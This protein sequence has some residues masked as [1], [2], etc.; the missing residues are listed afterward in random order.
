M[1]IDGVRQPIG[2]YSINSGA[3]TITFGSTPSGT[4]LAVT[5]YNL[6]D[7]QYL[8][9]QTITGVTVSS[10]ININNTISPALATTGVTAVNSAT[11]YLT[12]SNTS[13]FLLNA[14]VQFY[15]NA[16]LGNVDA[17]TGTVYFIKSIDS[18]TTF[19]ISTSPGGSVFD[20]GT[21]IGSI[22]AVVGGQPAV[23]V[24]TSSANLLSTNDI[25][26][27]SGTSGSVQLNE[28]LFYVHV[29]SSTQFD[30]YQTTYNPGAFVSNLPV[31]SITA[32]SGGGYVWKD[33]IFII[34]SQT[35]TAT[36]VNNK[37]TVGS[38]S[39][40]VVGTPI[41]FN[42]IGCEL[43][44]V[45][46]SNI[47]IGTKYFIHSITSSTEFTISTSHDG[48]IFDLTTQTG[49]FYTV[50][51]WEQ[52]IVDRLWV[53]VNGYRVAS[54]SLRLYPNND[55]GILTPIS[56][57]DSIIITSMIPTA[58]PNQL[59]YIQNVNK[60]G[61]SVVYRANSNISTWLTKSLQYTDT[62]IHL[63][64]VSNITSSTVITVSTPSPS[65]GVYTIG[66]PVDKNA[67]SEVIIYN[68]DA[69]VTLPSSYYRITVVDTV[70]VVQ[71]YNGVTVGQILTITVVLGNVIYIA[72]EAI[73]FSSV[74]FTTNT[75]S[76]LQRG[77][78][79]TSTPALIPID[80]R[81]YGILSPNQLLDEYYDMTWNS[82]NYNPV[83]GDPLQ[84]STTAPA[85]F[86][87]TGTS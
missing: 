21:A 45:T 72:G 77:V 36:N 60:S 59:T 28:Q 74:N 25:V 7:T 87:N 37:I 1:E 84:I 86:L 55:L 80:T 82:Y 61:S 17:T 73:R 81:V 2:N 53:T 23:R 54:S 27:I 76:G 10:I 22:V 30:L 40:L 6:T 3:N 62:I 78:N 9:T 14:T 44:Y 41:Y 4:T 83:L 5:T 35:A 71:I 64:N 48:S 38:T 79:G 26:R 50:S 12:A 39:N 11:K 43:G 24:T 58:T 16:N 42:C 63:D 66:L 19:T 18:S 8:N 57:G 75:I 13:N 29:I 31:T 46:A 51:Q 20:P 56:T 49:L 15:G 34:S 33:Q 32:Y 69:G 67:I 47:I 70:P 52:T 65:S 68:N 85:N